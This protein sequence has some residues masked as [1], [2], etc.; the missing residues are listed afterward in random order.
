MRP[1]D[2]DKPF[3]PCEPFDLDFYEAAP[4]RF[5]FEVE[6]P[7]TPEELFAILED[8]EPWTV[9]ASPGLTKVEWTSPKPY[10]PGTT[11]TVT[12]VGGLDVYEDFFVWEPPHRMAFFFYGATEKIWKRFGELY[13]V[14]A[15]EGGCRL[16]WTVAYDALGYFDFLQPLARWPMKWVL[17]GYMTKLRDYVENHQ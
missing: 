2:P 8:P 4:H 15:T 1:R 5:D 12:L 11:R 9:W 3:H 7:C 14:E 6:L 16:R 13:R 10:G 17:G